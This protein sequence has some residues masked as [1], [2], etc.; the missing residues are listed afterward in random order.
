VSSGQRYSPIVLKTKPYI[1][2]L[3]YHLSTWSIQ[4]SV[5]F[6]K[7]QRALFEDVRNFTVL[8]KNSIDFPGFGDSYRRRNIQDSATQEY[9]R[10]C[11]YNPKSAPYCPTF[12]IEDIV[13]LAGHK[14]ETVAKSGGVFAI[15]IRWDCSFDFGAS[16]RN[17]KPEYSFARLDNPDA[18]V[19]PGYSFW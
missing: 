14:F 17:C 11:V 3:N 19:A 9:L 12:R 6:R 1:F 10:Y 5:I 2:I 4:T 13:A 15:R 16:I 7:G 8:V 18:F